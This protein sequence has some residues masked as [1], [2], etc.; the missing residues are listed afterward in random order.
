[1]RWFARIFFLSVLLVI[2]QLA[3]PPLGTAQLDPCEPVEIPELCDEKP[4]PDPTEP[5]PD[6]GGGGGSDGGG[7]L[8]GG[9]GGGSTGGGSTGG[10]GGGGLTGGGGGGGGGGGSSNGGG[11]E[12]NPSKGPGGGT[13]VGGLGKVQQGPFVFG[14]SNDTQ[15]LITLLSKLKPYGVPLQQSLLRVAGPF[16]IAG[17][18]YWT[19]DWHAC[20][21]GCSRLHQGLDI[22]APTGAPLVAIADGV[23]TQKVVGE[24]SGISVE[25]QDAH[26]VQY[27]YAHLS[28]WAPG[29]RVGQQVERGDVIGFNGNTGNAI[30]TPPHLHL[31][32][33]PGGVPVPPKP[34]VDGWLEMA[35][36]RAIELV[37]SVTGKRISV[38][39]IAAG[40]NYRLT[41]LFDL[42]GEAGT[43]TASGEQLLTL[44]GIQPSSLDLTTRWI[45]QMSWEIDWASQSDAELAELADE[46]VGQD[47]SGAS[48]WAPLGAGASQ[49][50]DDQEHAEVGD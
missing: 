13:G 9:D 49:G 47:L 39:A 4:L 22:F 5:L 46:L 44:L 7:T 43:T 42:D 41:R 24:L 17:P 1:M 25:I 12:A 38:A 31:E 18:A 20:R 15:R 34:F 29:L 48:P 21:D 14:G 11:G 6:D 27:F 19:N 50:A 10:G 16:P 36:R 32:I 45:G 26:G 28:G 8:P 35:E 33:Q 30:Y 37:E 23:V 3:L 40:S 2:Q